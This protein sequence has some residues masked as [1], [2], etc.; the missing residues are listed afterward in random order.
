[1]HKEK[2]GRIKTWTLKVNKAKHVT[3]AYNPSYSESQDQ[4]DPSSRLA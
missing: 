3:H 4:E 1:M 2:E